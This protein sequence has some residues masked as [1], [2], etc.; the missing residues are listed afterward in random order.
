MIKRVFSVEVHPELRAEFEDK[1]Q[2][3]ALPDTLAADGCLSVEIYKPSPSNPNTYLMISEW[4]SELALQ[5]KFGPDWHLASIPD[6][7]KKFE[8]SH[9]IAHYESWSDEESGEH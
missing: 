6:I 1:F 3:L 8:R 9:T 5:E 7:M 4:V 2:R